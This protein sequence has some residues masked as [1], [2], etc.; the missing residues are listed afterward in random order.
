MRTMLFGVLHIHMS[1]LFR[2]LRLL[3]VFFRERTVRVEQLCP[4]QGFL[5]QAFVRGR[6][7][8]VRECCGE[9][10]AMDRKQNLAFLH[11]VPEPD[12]QDQRRARKPCEVT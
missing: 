9:I 12:F 5:R 10:G 1:F 2:V 4:V 7:L 8:I 11:V 3:Q 6:L